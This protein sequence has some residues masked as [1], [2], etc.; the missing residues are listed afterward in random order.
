MD[1]VTLIGV[2][3]FLLVI[4]LIAPFVPARSGARIDLA[5]AL[6]RELREKCHESKAHFWFLRTNNA[7]DGNMFSFAAFFA[8]H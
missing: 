8:P 5:L 2:G 4:A 3:L 6:D 7:N 1:P